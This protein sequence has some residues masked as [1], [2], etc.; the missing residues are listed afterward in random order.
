MKLY[1]IAGEGW[2][3]WTKVRVLK[4]DVKT[5]IA[6]HGVKEGDIILFNHIDGMYSYCKNENGDIIHPA[7][8]TEVEIVKE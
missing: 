5:P 1:E 6:S 7:A 2:N 3:N 8:W 4:Q